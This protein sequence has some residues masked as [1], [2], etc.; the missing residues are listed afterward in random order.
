MTPFT[1]TERPST[2]WSPHLGQTV[3]PAVPAAAASSYTSYSDEVLQKSLWFGLGLAVS[4]PSSLALYAVAPTLRVKQ[5]NALI[6]ATVFGVVGIAATLLP[7]DLKSM[8]F[9][10]RISGVLTGVGL[11]KATLPEPSRKKA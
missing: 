4:Y 10:A 2:P 1:F 9:L 7:F 5:K 3:Q 8:S 6:G 11:S